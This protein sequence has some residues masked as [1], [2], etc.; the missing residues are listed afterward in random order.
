MFYCGNENCATRENHPVNKI[1]EDVKHRAELRKARKEKL[2]AKA[3]EKAKQ[4][5]KSA[6]KK[7]KA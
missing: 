5:K 2:A 4:P 1:L 6:R 3:A 7:A